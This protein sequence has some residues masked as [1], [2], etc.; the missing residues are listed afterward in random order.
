[1]Q[2]GSQSRW[3][4]PVGCREPGSLKILPIGHTVRLRQSTQPSSN[5]T[6]ARRIPAP[7][8]HARPHDS[9]RSGTGCDQSRH[10]RPGRAGCRL[11]DRVQE[12]SDG[13][14]SQVH[15]R[16]IACGRGRTRGCSEGRFDFPFQDERAIKRFEAEG[17]GCR[18]DQRRLRNQPHDLA[19]RNGHRVQG[20]QGLHGFEHRMDGCRAI[21]GQI[22]G[23]LHHAAGG[24]VDPDRFH[25]RHA[26]VRLA[27][28]PGD[29]PGDFEI[30]RSQID[31]EGDQWRSGSDHDRPCGPVQRG[32]TEV[33]TPPGVRLHPTRQPF[34]PPAPHGFQRCAVR[35][36]GRLLIEKYGNPQLSSHSFSEAPGQLH[37]VM[38]RDALGRHKGNDVRG[39]DPWMHPAVLPDVDQPGR[40]LN[41]TKRRVGRRIRFAHERED[42]PM[43][44]RIHRPVQQCHARHRLYGPDQGANGRS[45]PSLA[46]VRH[47][48]YQVLHSLPLVQ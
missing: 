4:S 10:R 26:S 13:E 33:R 29:R 30:R 15:S 47:A 16:L 7:T 3:A 14:A 32:G 6:E 12:L 21:V 8:T 24:Q 31:V 46:E 48:S 43:M 20:G 28:R 35:S 18:I 41:G 17:I 36:R 9:Q 37:A 25:M 40:R 39:A 44:V 1:M 19:A 2:R 23:H 27:D 11:R 38:R 42:G 22:R 5:G 45:V 34:H